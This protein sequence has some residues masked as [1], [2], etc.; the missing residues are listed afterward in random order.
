MITEY[1]EEA[2]KR[3]HYDIIEDEEPFY[4]EIEELQGVWATGKTLEACRHNLKE[5]IEGWIL[6]SIKK[7]L[8]IPKLGEMEIKELVK[9]TQ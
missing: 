4:G 7:G 9:E 2:L 5:V 6:I 1:I 3:A 8:I